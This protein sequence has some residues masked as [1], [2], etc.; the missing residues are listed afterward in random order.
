LPKPCSPSIWMWSKHDT[1]PSLQ[2]S[3]KRLAPGMDAESHRSRP[4]EKTQTRTMQH[5]RPAACNLPLS[6]NRDRLRLDLGQSRQHYRA[7]L[8]RQSWPSLGHRSR[9]DSSREPEG[10]T[11][12]YLGRSP[13]GSHSAYPKLSVHRPASWPTRSRD[14]KSAAASWAAPSLAANGPVRMVRI[15]DC[16]REQYDLRLGCR[17]GNSSS[18]G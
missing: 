2:L 4:P 3:E 5:R 16:H 18:S 8:P 9:P 14:P 13:P 6:C 1:P 17:A 12:H 10:G 7:P 11:A 15:V